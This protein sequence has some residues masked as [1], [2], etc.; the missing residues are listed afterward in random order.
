[1]GNV[2]TTI[3]SATDLKVLSCI[4]LWELGLSMFKP[5]RTTLLRITRILNGF[6]N[7]SKLVDLQTGFKML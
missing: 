6:L 1:M 4:E 5:L 7:L 2:I 3:H